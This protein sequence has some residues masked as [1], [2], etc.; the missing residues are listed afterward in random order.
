MKNGNW[1]T[2][3]LGIVATLVT[4]FITNGIVFQRDTREQLAKQSEQIANIETRADN[5]IKYLNEKITRLELHVDRL[6]R[7]PK[8]SQP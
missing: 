6:E 7:Q 5:I 1:R 3:L 4:A 2:W 8:G